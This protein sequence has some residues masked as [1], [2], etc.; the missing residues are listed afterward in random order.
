MKKLLVLVLVGILMITA[1]VT[2]GCTGY[3]KQTGLDCKDGFETARDYGTIKY[4]N[5]YGFNNYDRAI[6]SREYHKTELHEI[7]SEVYRVD[8]ND[9]TWW[10]KAVVG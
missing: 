8:G 5:I 7:V 2:T 6:K 9:M 10:F 1:F 3:S 4:T